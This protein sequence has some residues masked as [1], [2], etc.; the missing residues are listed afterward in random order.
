MTTFAEAASLLVPQGYPVFPL[1]QDKRP[2]TR[3]GFKEATTDTTRIEAWGKRW[4]AALV[5]VPTGKASNLF[6]LDVDVKNGKDGFGTVR[7]K[8]WELPATRTHRTKNGGGAHYLFQLPEGQPLKNSVGKLGDGLDTRGEGGYIVWWPA[9]GGEVENP[10]LMASVPLFLLDALQEQPAPSGK[11]EKANAGEITEGVRNN[12]MFRLASSLRAKGLTV[13]AIEAALIVEN[14]AKCNPP[15]PEHEVRLIARSTG[16]YAEGSGGTPDEATLARLATLSLFDYDRVR[17][18]EAAALGVRPGILDKLVAAARDEES[19]ADGLPFPAVEP[20]PEPIDPAQLL[21]EVSDTIKRFIVLD[22]EQAHAA[23]LWVAFTWFIDVVDVAPLAIISA[24]EKSCGKSQLLFLFGKM[25]CKPLLAS[26]MRAATLFRM[27]EKWRP[28]ML[29]DEADTFIKTDEDM[30]GLINAGH[31]RDAALAWRLV[32]DDFEPK[33]F[34]VWGAK[35]LAGIA[36]E[37]HLPDTTMSR[38]IIFEMRRKLEHESVSRL[39]DAASGVFED[40]TA[41]LA[42]FAADYS[43]DVRL[44]RPTLPDAL[45]DRAQDNWEPLLAIAACAGDEWVERAAKAALKLS[46]AGDKTVSTGNE[47]LADIQDVFESKGVDKISTAG[48]IAALVWDEEKT[49]ATY[50]RGKPISAKQ[51][52]RQLTGYGIRSKTVRLGGETA[53][54]FEVSQFSDAFAR[55]LPKN[56]FLSV[57]ASQTSPSA[58]S[59]VTDSE[60]VPAIKNL[61]VTLEPAPQVGCDAVTDKMP[62]LGVPARHVPELEEECDLL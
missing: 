53:K 9:H 57:T 14:Q 32:G 8:G 7:G 61:S 40:I 34:N 59:R 5:G 33:S 58:A 16:R 19:D 29:I 25:A 42:R 55:Y 50:N 47:L 22:D 30:A 31:T 18:D 39:R 2:H 17:K 45:S 60:N 41:K 13:E 56:G 12:T 62:V 10:D 52:A 46:G 24:P 38:G 3:S 44:A 36:L 51:I 11:S 26:N 6:V 54:G 4:P 48:L 1:N 28:A 15:L 49:W 27:A 20:H 23:A 35:A 37:R 21:S 43:Q